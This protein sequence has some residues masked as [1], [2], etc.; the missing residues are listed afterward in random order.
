MDHEERM[1]VLAVATGFVLMNPEH[2]KRCNITIYKEAKSN[3][4]EQ[5]ASEDVE[6]AVANSAVNIAN[7]ALLRIEELDRQQGQGQ[8]QG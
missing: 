8:E 3:G 7:H 2:Y 6:K 1:M 4:M 5:P